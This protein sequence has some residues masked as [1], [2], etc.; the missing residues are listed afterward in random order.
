[1]VLTFNNICLPLSSIF[2]FGGGGLAG[3]CWKL[4]YIL[5]EN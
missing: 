4:V 3:R 2:F 5:F 1:M